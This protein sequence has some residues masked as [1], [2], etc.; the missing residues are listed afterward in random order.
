VSKKRKAHLNNMSMFVLGC[1]ILLV[2]V[3]A[4]D[5]VRDANGSKKGI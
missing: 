2:G 5:M 1:P 3:G 4:R